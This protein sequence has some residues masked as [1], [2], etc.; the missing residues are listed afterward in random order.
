MRLNQVTVSMPDLDEGWRFY[1]TLGLRPIVDNRPKYVRFLCPQG[2]STF[3]IAKGQGGGGSH[4][5]FECDDVDQT[6][7][8]LRMAGIGGISDPE[9]KSWLWREAE[10]SDPGGNSIVLY[11]PGKNR[12]DPPWRLPEGHDE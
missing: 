10:L 9:D 6:V 2:D 8:D 11:Q 1:R 12:I 5:Y 4:V 3:S 7:R